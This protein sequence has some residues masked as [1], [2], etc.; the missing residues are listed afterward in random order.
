MDAYPYRWGANHNVTSVDEAWGPQLGAGPGDDAWL[1]PLLDR[2]ILID[3]YGLDGEPEY[4]T[5][6]ELT[7]VSLP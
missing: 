4:K 7:G 6:S 1:V 3:P 5:V 2:L